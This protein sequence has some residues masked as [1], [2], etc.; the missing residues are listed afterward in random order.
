MVPFVTSSLDCRFFSSLD[1][2]GLVSS[3]RSDTFTGYRDIREVSPIRF[4]A[5]TALW[6]SS[7]SRLKFFHEVPLCTFLG[8]C[9]TVGFALTRR[10]RAFPLSDRSINLTRSI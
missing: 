9:S 8:G 2:R 5:C 7:N 6:L 1:C 3:D 10:P 4:G